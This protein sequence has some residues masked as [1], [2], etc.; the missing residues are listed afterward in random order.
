ML[1]RD[2]VMPAAEALGLLLKTIAGKR[3]VIVPSD[4]QQALGM[5]CAE[6]VIAGEN[7]P[8]FA[9]STVDGYAVRA[10]D[11]FGATEGM[12]AYL[13]LSAEVFMGERA[14]DTITDDLACKIPTG[15]ML[16][17]GSDAVVM[18]EHVQVIDDKM[19]EV[20]KPVAP[21]ENVI[22]TGEDIRMGEPVLMK[23]R[24]IRPQDIGACAGIGVTELKVFARPV[25]SIISTGDEIVP[26][27]RIPDVGQIRDTNSYTI[28]A[29]VREA[30]G[31]PVRKGIFRD[32]YASIRGAVEDAMKDSDVIAVSGGT[33]V[34]TKDMIARIIGDIGNPGILFHGV[35]LKPGK[36]AIGGV[37]SGVPIFGLPG[38]P[39]AVSVCFDIF[40]RPVLELLSGVESCPAY[41]LRGIVR[42]RLSRNVPSSQGREE[43]IRARIEEREDGMWAVPIL[44]KSGLIRTLVEAD[45]TFVIPVNRNGIEKGEL[46]DI[47]LF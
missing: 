5:V 29:M 17:A 42:A 38:H 37:M 33:S 39:A 2:R 44:G 19:I 8:A 23:G 35:S 6:S 43:H 32:D 13:N 1:G 15:G 31:V 20:M 30:G 22:Q 12:P 3:T 41:R 25:V 16:P 27:E 14:E 46:V 24:R 26:A 9:R 47:R 34:G 10:E 28:A 21:G 18:F 40:I 11:T 45:G 7:V 4:I 36:P